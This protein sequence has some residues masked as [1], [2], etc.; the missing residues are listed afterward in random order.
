MLPAHQ[1][2]LITSDC[3]PCRCYTLE[4]SN[5]GA[6]MPQTGEVEAFDAEGYVEIGR[7]LGSAFSDLYQ[8]PKPNVGGKPASAGGLA[9]SSGRLG[10]SMLS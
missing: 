4:V 3:A 9:Q 6:L 2:A 1:M 10:K 5:F 8:P 7:A